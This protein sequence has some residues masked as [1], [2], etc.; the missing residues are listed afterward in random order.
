MQAPAVSAVTA[1]PNFTAVTA[2]P[3]AFDSEPDFGGG[4]ES[5]WGNRLDTRSV[6]GRSFDKGNNGNNGNNGNDGDAAAIRILVTSVTQNVSAPV[7][8][9]SV[10]ATATQAAP[11]SDASAL[12]APRPGASAPA[13]SAPNERPV[14]IA[15][16]QTR[17]AA[18]VALRTDFQAVL[19]L[20]Q[21]DIAVFGD[22]GPGWV[23]ANIATN[24]DTG[25]TYSPTNALLVQVNDP[26][27]VPVQVGW[28]EGGPVYQAAEGVWLE[29]SEVAFAAAYRAQSAA[30]PS[31]ALQTL[32]TSYATNDAA[33][34]TEQPGLWDVAISDHALNAGPAPAGVAMG[35]AAQLGMTDL[36]LAD[37]Q[38]AAIINAY[39]GTPEPATSPMALEQVRLYG[40]NR[41]NQ[42]TRLGTAMQSV[43]D[44]YGVALAD[45]QAGRGGGNGT[46]GWVDRP[47]DVTTLSITDESGQSLHFDA[48]PFER[49]F[50]PD[51]FSAWYISQ[52]GLANQ[53]FAEHY[54]ASHTDYATDESGRSFASSMSF[55]N[56]PWSA[57]G[58]GQG[59]R[60][61]ELSGINLND[62]PDLHH[63]EAVGF[64]FA[65]GWSTSHANIDHGTDWFDTVAKLVIIAAVAWVSAGTLGPAVAG[66]MGLNEVAVGAAVTAADLNVAGGNA[67]G[68]AH[69]SL[70][71]PSLPPAPDRRRPSW[72]PIGFAPQPIDLALPTALAQRRARRK[73]H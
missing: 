11:L 32:A 28:D 54:G 51:A 37:P 1:A 61:S 17:E 53:A 25:Q 38:T 50:D 72:L 58:N 39:G 42:L 64:D 13:A 41:Y 70:S 48:I 10:L 8:G 21:S 43:R 24:Q 68:H 71:L 67:S 23:A 6:N 60:H 45:A 7:A 65:V 56:A 52:P 36:Y 62:P 59:M 26:N 16:L 47:I 57:G 2:A 27:A 33:V 18:L 14:D 15:W 29:F 35:N 66:S 40:P 19:A 63:A 31:A 9:A 49:V 20:A 34:F 73:S 44:Q 12:T 5:H 22:I 4:F 69:A 55:A 46:A 3:D 30:N